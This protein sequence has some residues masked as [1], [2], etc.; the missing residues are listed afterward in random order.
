MFP[1]TRPS[2][3]QE[4]RSD[5]ER[6][7]ARSRASLVAAYWKPVYKYV[8]LRWRREPAD[9]EDLTQ[10][11]FAH[12]LDR[13]VLAQF[14]GERA[15]FRTFLRS[16][17]DRFAIDEHRRATAARRGGGL[18]VEA[19]FAAAERELA[20]S[21]PPADVEATF[22]AEW[23]RHLVAVAL[24]RLDASFAAKKK[25]HHAAL[26]HRFHLGEAPPSYSD[27]ARELG[28]TVT[29]VTNW[30]SIARREF[31]RIALELLREITATEAEFIDEA[32]A[33]FGIEVKAT[34]PSAGP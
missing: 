5:D 27:A 34:P 17:L 24:E 22:D 26:F 13:D 29:D 6:R 33:V 9:A 14:D 32:R 25:P 30:L 11:F 12:A 1:V 15:R 23:V 8:R 4:L 10:S 19:D 3:I 28:I 7:R 31:R 21:T 18:R 2:L 20:A 16:C